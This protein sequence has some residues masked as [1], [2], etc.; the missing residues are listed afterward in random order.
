MFNLVHKANFGS[1]L[2]VEK[3]KKGKIIADFFR[4]LYS[5]WYPV[6]SKWFFSLKRSQYAIRADTHKAVCNT[7]QDSEHT[8]H[9]IKTAGKYR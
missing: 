2:T 3:R 8:G 4:P 7:A 9:Q 6:Y 1:N 5:Q